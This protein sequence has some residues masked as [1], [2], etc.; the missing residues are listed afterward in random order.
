MLLR[1][2]DFR[3][4]ARARLPRFVFDYVDGGAEDEACL[5]RNRQAL[6]ELRLVPRVMRDTREVDLSVEVF[7]RRW[8]MPAGIAPVGFAGL[9]RPAGDVLLAK[10]AAAQG[11]PFVLSTASNAR[12]EAVRA[13][14]PQAVQW[15]QLYVMGDRSIAEQIVRRAREARFDALV[16]TVDVAVS[17]MRERDMRNGF[18]LPFRPGLRTAIDLAAH[19]AWSIAA[20][21]AG[22]PGFANLVEDPSTPASPQ[23]QAALLARAMD[24]GLTWESLA[25]L[26]RLWDGPL[27]VKGVLGPADAASA[28]AHGA[29]GLVVSNHGGRQL[30][31]VPAAISALPGVIDAVRGRIP[32]FV[33]SGFRRGSDVAKALAL[34]ATA[35]FM[36]RL[37]IWGL[38]AGGQAGVEQALALVKAE[39]ERTLILLGVP[40]A[41]AL[42]HGGLVFDERRTGAANE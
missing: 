28:V 26:R 40:H 29:D 3:R 16:L 37:P 10:A 21:L 25:W 18:R 2:A 35:A 23:V 14:A 42:A 34:G 24:R 13:A 6:D 8:S 30:D 31:V 22:T 1:T 19:P 9:V 27:L 32:V 5:A 15:M 17:G 36:G 11:V 4:R 39:F 41:D 38:A 20:A 12:L 33:D 7:G